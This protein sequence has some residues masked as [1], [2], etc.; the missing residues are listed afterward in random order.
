M[1]GDPVFID[2]A[3]EAN[4]EAWDVDIFGGNDGLVSW[5]PTFADLDNDGLEDLLVG[6]GGADELDF[7]GMFG[8]DYLDQNPIYVYR[9]LG[10]GTFEQKSDD[11]GM[12]LFGYHRGTSV[13][14]VDADGDL[15]V[16]VGVDDGFNR[17][18]V[19][20]LNN[21]NWLKIDV[22]GRVS[23]RDGI[24][25]KIVVTAGDRSQMREIEGGSSFLSLSCRTAHFGLGQISELETIQATF[26]SG[27]D[28]EFRNVRSDRW[29]NAVEPT[30][31]VVPDVTDVVTSP[32]SPFSTAM[33]FT[34]FGDD[35]AAFDTWVGVIRPDG[36]EIL[37]RGPLAQSLNAGDSTMQTLSFD[38]PA[39]AGLGDY[40]LVLRT[41]VFPDEINDQTFID[42][43]LE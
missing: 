41:G 20:E 21:S 40:V 26:P 5:G 7:P 43:T 15:D 11:I 19:N 25:T 4:V 18:Y 28:I 12:D 35:V 17:F 6:N 27:I 30:V 36:S 32:G 34:N 39:G 2:V 3:T 29:I 37:F 22:E 10:D 38:V 16:H 31:S 14:D 33:E 42:M 9:N 24:G 23:N 1:Q 13:C 8:S